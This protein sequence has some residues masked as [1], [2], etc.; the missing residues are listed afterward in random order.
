MP[1]ICRNNLRNSIAITDGCSLLDRVVTNYLKGLKEEG[2]KEELLP[3]WLGRAGRILSISEDW[4]PLLIRGAC[5]Y[6]AARTDILPSAGNRQATRISLLHVSS[7]S[8]VI[9]QRERG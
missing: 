2:L 3:T 7:L 4:F 5:E 6:A 9:S 8:L 1:S